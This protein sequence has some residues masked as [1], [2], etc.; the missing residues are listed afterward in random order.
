MLTRL[1]ARVVSLLL[2][3]AA[4]AGCAASQQ[5]MRPAFDLTI[6]NEGNLDREVETELTLDPQAL[7]RLTAQVTNKTDAPLRR[8]FLER[9]AHAVWEGAEIQA[10][11]AAR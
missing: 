3:A 2:L 1:Q 11:A 4:T 10:A 7:A 9:S 6:N 8:W 5:E